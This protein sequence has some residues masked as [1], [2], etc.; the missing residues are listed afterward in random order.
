MTRCPVR[1]PHRHPS[2]RLP[3]SQVAQVKTE[4]KPTRP[5]PT[6]TPNKRKLARQTPTT[7]P[8]TV[9]PIT[10]V[11]FSIGQEVRRQGDPAASGGTAESA[12]RGSQQLWPVA[13]LPCTE[14]QQ[15]LNARGAGQRDPQRCTCGCPAG[16]RCGADTPFLL[17]NGACIS[18]KLVGVHATS[19]K[20]AVFPW[21][22]KGLP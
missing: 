17:R 18:Q 10:E 11:T 2:P 6:A 7:A 1:R 21:T 3:V 12:Y 5:P 16:V 9:V 14:P 22:L 13:C 20:G 4:P 19:E 8:T 15:H